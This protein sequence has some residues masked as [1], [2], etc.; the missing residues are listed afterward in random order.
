MHFALRIS[1]IA[2]T[3][4]ILVI[5]PENLSQSALPHQ[6]E[7]LSAKE[8][9]Q[10]YRYLVHDQV[11]KIDAL[12]NRY[13]WFNGNVMVVKDHKAIYERAHGFANYQTREPL[14]TASVF[15]L[16]SVSKQFTAIAILQ[17][18]ERQLISVDDPVHLYIPELPYKNIT[19]RQLLNHTSGLPNYM[20][21]LENFWNQSHLPSNEE[22]IRM[23][24]EHHPN[25]FFWAGR[26]Y[27]YSNTGYAMLASVIERVT[28]KSFTQF[29]HENIFGPLGMRNTFT[30]V[31]ILD[32]TF[33]NNNFARGHHQAWRRFRL[34]TTV[35]HDKV[36]G[37]K[38]IHSNM[39][40]LYKWDQALYTGKIVCNTI[41]EQAY[42]PL[43]FSNR[44]S[45][46]YG[47]GFRIGN[48]NGE[49]YV[50]HHGLWEGFRTSLVRHIERG[51]AIV[52]LN[53]TNQ[54]VNSQI[55]RQIQ[56]ILDEP[57]EYSPTRL[58]ALEIINEGLEAAQDLF[59]EM[60]QK[61]E[62]QF[63][64]AN[65]LFE[66]AGLLREMNKPVLSSRVYKFYETT[67]L[68]R[69]AELPVAKN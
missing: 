33:T 12:M 30:S 46:P 61:G 69:E 36:L 41:L 28:G 50:Y 56:N 21:V 67:S 65:E 22:M 1:M 6:T 29:L 18:C 60:V 68:C 62:I 34:N 52:I 55:I 49:K 16:A 53:N 11:E 20:W 9:A 26:R 4:I 57:V 45:L 2:F 31:E 14:T 13:S 66:I 37:D 7:F 48:R 17:L 10:L 19:I 25:Q 44:R 51:D 40:D 59:D 39:E 24:V 54:R 58:I 8:E 47:F 3:F 5:L 23:L 42:Q 38:G 15:E 35:V 32:T 64:D 27:S 43:T 63:P